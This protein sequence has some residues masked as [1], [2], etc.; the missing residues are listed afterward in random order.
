MHLTAL[1]LGTALAATVFTATASAQTAVSPLDR[2]SLEGSSFTHFPLGR[3]N[4]RFQFLHADLPPGMVLHGHAFRRDATQ[5]RGVVDAFAADM[6]VTLSIS[7]NS[8]GQASPTFANN[9]GANATIVLPRTVVL[10]PSTDRPAL[11]PSPT[12][13][14]MVPYALPFVL[15]ATPATLCVDTV[16]F[17]NTSAAGVDRSLSIYIDSHELTT[18]GTN[19]QPGFRMGTGCPPPGATSTS[20]ATMT[21]FHLGT[22]MRLDVSARNGLPD[23]GTGTSFC[24]LGFGSS[25]SNYPWPFRPQCVLQTLVDQV[26]VLGQNDLA[27]SFDG[28]LAN[29]PVLPPGLR[30]YLQ[31][32][33]LAVGSNDLTVGDVTTIVTPGPGPTTLPAVRI[34]A[35]TNRLATT[36]TVS[37]S[38]PVTQFF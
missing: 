36:G 18:N 37:P 4:A 14:L 7:P 24:L 2:T 38:V 26:F 20:F 13:D 15:P 17:G 25:P 27:G 16:M 29:Q 12:F 8:P 31:A 6:Q 1:A 35:S 33:S 22:S 21:L 3:P 23:D 30:M 11:D 9:T 10:F 5:V 19:E 32:G 34:A 28:S